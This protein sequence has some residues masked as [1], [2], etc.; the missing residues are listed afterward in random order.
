M[1]GTIPIVIFALI[2]GMVIGFAIPRPNDLALMQPKLTP[3][4]RGY[5]I[6]QC[7]SIQEQVTGPTPV[8]GARPG[9]RDACLEEIRNI[10]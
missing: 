9:S 4:E 8:P 10:P 5:L 6:T 1:G 2:V 3:N 7:Y